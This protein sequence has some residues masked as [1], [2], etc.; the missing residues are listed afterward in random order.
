LG[1]GDPLPSQ[2]P[3]PFARAEVD[4]IARLFPAAGRRVL[5]GAQATRANVLAALPGATHLHFSCHG[6]FDL[7]APLASALQ[8]SGE[9]RLTLRDL[10]DGD[11]DL[12]TV[13]LAV[14]SACQ[15]GIADMFHVPDE[16]VGLPG[17]FLQA[18]VPGV[19]GT[20]WPVVDLSTALL[21]ERFYRHHLCEGL[22]PAVALNRAQRWLREAT[23][24]ELGLVAR[25]EQR[26]AAPGQDDAHSLRWL[27]YYRAHPDLRPFAHPYYWAAF[28][29]TGL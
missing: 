16:A 8:L 27:R 4:D 6:A 10:L 12:R 21:L 7:D 18:G 11:L 13:Q 3:I 20:L 5:G 22:H 28:G 9:D 26:L 24:R 1:I 29:Y 25:Y 17:G 2:Q 15:T 19:I 23:T 14:L